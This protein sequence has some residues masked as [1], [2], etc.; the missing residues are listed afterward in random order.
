[1]ALRARVLSPRTKTGTDKNTGFTKGG[2][3]DLSLALGSYKVCDGPGF[4]PI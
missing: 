1:M 3:A 2:G 4:Q